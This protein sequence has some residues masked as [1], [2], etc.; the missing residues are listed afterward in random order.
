MGNQRIVLP[1]HR[2][3]VFGIAA[4]AGAGRHMSPRPRSLALV[5]LATYLGAI[6]SPIDSLAAGAPTAASTSASADVGD[7]LFAAA[8]FAGAERAYRSMLNDDEHDARA[9]LGLAR[10]ALYRNDLAEAERYADALVAANPTDA[11]AKRILAVAAGRRGDGPDYRVTMPGPEVDVPFRRVDPLP[12]LDAR[13]DGKP[14]RL[15][16]DTGGDGLDLSPAFVKSIGL[17][18]TAGGQGTFAGGLRATVRTGHVEQLDL[19]AAAIRSI[20]VSVP[21]E[22][23]PGIDGVLGT[24]ILYQFLSTIDYRGGRLVLRPKD[25]SPAFEAAARGRGAVVLP[26]LLV[27]SHFIFVRARVGAAP[28]ALFNV[29]TGGGGIGVQ[30]TKAALDAAG[31]VPDAAHP[32]SF[33]GGGGT[34]RT[35]PFAAD[36]KLGSLTQRH[37]PG[38]YFPDGDQYGIF[39]FAV[40]GTI[41]HELFKRGT[42]TFDFRAMNVLFELPMPAASRSSNR[43]LRGALLARAPVARLGRRS[44]EREAGN[45]VRAE[46][47]AGVSFRNR[48]GT[49]GIER[50][51]NATV[52]IARDQQEGRVVRALGHG[53]DAAARRSVTPFFNR[54]RGRFRDERRLADRT[55]CG[56]RGDGRSGVRYLSRD[57]G[58]E[59]ARK[60]LGEDGCEFRGTFAPGESADAVLVR[61]AAVPNLLD[62]PIAHARLFVYRAQGT[63]RANRLHRLAA[64]HAERYVAD[65][66]CRDVERHHCVRGR[67]PTGEHRR[68]PERRRKDPYRERNEI[69]SL[70]RWSLSAS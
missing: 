41:S 44:A 37:V 15:L 13:V 55:N 48:A 51:P 14:A 22:L 38:V 42:L 2:R 56:A 28:E 32:A 1:V 60:P 30:L 19:G 33:E 50:A 59:S 36:V 49:A 65:G 46:V 26:M 4:P 24:T 25:A 54:A 23:P 58:A 69:S 20:P 70:H 11:R 68:P 7:R 12:E 29:D 18:T 8:D 31:I 66:K 53:I 35:L 47:L 43:R 61:L 57:R 40:A 63:V 21:E 39:P 6:A 16:L 5:A 17:T 67:R 45:A 62:E 34:T 64:S 52:G 9:E 3:D 27:P 10:I